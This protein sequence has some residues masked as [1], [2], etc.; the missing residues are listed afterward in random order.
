M[1]SWITYPQATCHFQF[2]GLRLFLYILAKFFSTSGSS[3]VLPRSSTLFLRTIPQ[4]CNFLSKD[5]SIWNFCRAR[6]SSFT[7]SG[8]QYCYYHII[9]FITLIFCLSTFTGL[10]TYNIWKWRRVFNI[11]FLNPIKIWKVSYFK[12]CISCRFRKSS[13]VHLEL[14]TLNTE[15]LK[16]HLTNRSH[17][18]I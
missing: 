10:E 15:W 12:F 6:R 16:S 1:A 3:V 11:I 9:I 4:F 2:L 13:G 5:R 14:I 7:S 8:Q 18:S 17:Y